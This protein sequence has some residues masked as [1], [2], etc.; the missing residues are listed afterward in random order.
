MTAHQN[1][2][3]TGV[4][5]VGVLYYSSTYLFYRL[6][7]GLFAEVFDRLLASL[8]TSARQGYSGSHFRQLTGSGI[9]DAGVGPSHD[10]VLPSEILCDRLDLLRGHIE[11]YCTKVYERVHALFT[12]MYANGP[13]GSISLELD[14]LELPESVF[15]CCCLEVLVYVAIC[16]ESISFDAQLCSLQEV[17]SELGYVRPP[18]ETFSRVTNYGQHFAEHEFAH[19]GHIALSTESEHIKNT[20]DSYKR[21][22]L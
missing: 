16:T 22:K 6:C 21:F 3:S 13:T 12:S 19:V 1:L 8:S 15:F 2:D 9:P 5:S 14:T 18:S 7:Q 10:E 17:E 20:C 11:R 4:L